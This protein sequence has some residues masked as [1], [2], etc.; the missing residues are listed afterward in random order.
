MN[1]PGN[2]FTKRHSE[3]LIQGITNFTVC[4]GTRESLNFDVIRAITE[5]KLKLI[6]GVF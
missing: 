5:R 1:I 2:S 6:R 3:R 4:K